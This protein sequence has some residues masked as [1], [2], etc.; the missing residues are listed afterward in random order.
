MQTLLIALAASAIVV[1][2]CASS[3]EPSTSQEI[4]G[5][6]LALRNQPPAGPNEA[7]MDALA[8]G[9]LAINER[10]GLGLEIGTDKMAVA[11]PF[12]FTAWLIDGTPTLFD[13]QGHVLARAGDQIQMG[14]G[15]GAGD[16]W[17]PCADQ[18]SAGPAG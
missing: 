3:P 5:Q 14:G 17:Y 15:F 6:Q 4:G 12:G 1:A 8:S 7:C 18:I 16:F 10:S 2:A 13:A 11:W 9:T